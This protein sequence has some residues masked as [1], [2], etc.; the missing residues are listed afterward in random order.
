MRAAPFPLTEY[1]KNVGPRNFACAGERLGR[2]GL[3]RPGRWCR[4]RACGRGQRSAPSPP[5]RGGRGA[6][7][8]HGPRRYREARAD[9]R[10]KQGDG[11]ARLRVR[12]SHQPDRPSRAG[13]GAA[14]SAGNPARPPDRPRSAARRHRRAGTGGS[15]GGFSP[16]G[17][18][19][20]ARAG[21]GPGDGQ[22]HLRLPRPRRVRGSGEERQPKVRWRDRQAADA[23]RCR[24][25]LQLRR[26]RS[27]RW[28]PGAARLSHRH[29]GQGVR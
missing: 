16:P 6:D 3:S 12:S 19:G 11:R 24:V 28:L 18:R 15:P 4:V 22:R 13:A 26:L 29:H 9:R 14:G 1:T 2:A 5:D 21:L 10:R 25:D 23:Q 27:G 17:S 20:A 8:H 7:R